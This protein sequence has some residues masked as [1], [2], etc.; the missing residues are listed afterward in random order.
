MSETTRSLASI[1]RQ[2]L[3]PRDLAAVFFRHKKLFA[4]SFVS[5]LLVGVAY[6]ALFPT[7]KSEATFQLGKARIDPAVTALPNVSPLLQSQEIGEEE[8]NSQVELLRDDEVLR[9]V[10]ERTGLAQPRSWLP[11]WTTRNSDQR[12]EKTV[13][14]L[15]KQIDIQPVRKSR[16]I[17]ISY[18]ATDPQLA[19]SVVK[20]LAEVYLARQA[21]LRRPAG[22]AAFFD[23]QVRESRQALHSAQTALVRFS[24]NG[25]VASASLERDLNVQKLVEAQASEMGLQAGIAETQERIRA[26]DRKMSDLPEHRVTQ[27]H[28]SDNPQLQEKL[29]SRLLELQLKRTE[30]LTKFQPSYR[31][32]QEADQEIAQA[33]AALKAEVA[34]PLRDEV[35]EINPDYTWASAERVKCLIDLQGLEKRLQIVGAQISKYQRASETL[36]AEVIEQ[37]DLEQA[38]KAAED[39]YLLYANKRE[40]ARIGD[41]LDS[42]GILNV[43]LAQPPRVPTV[44]VLPLLAG[45][46]LSFA[47]ALL[48]SIALVFVVDRLDPTVRTPADVIELLG[49]PVLAT[50]PIAPRGGTRMRSA[51]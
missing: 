25:K 40:E 6:T 14:R 27:V 45:I 26:L 38:V 33:E 11:E 22:Q 9:Q 5:T 35:T 23:E 10:S 24:R 28:N 36:A 50:F 39:K 42:K 15:K 49:A 46:W 30:L 13:A 44:P 12:L 29:K 17:A 41:A 7:Y 1:S 34:R 20:T 21:N 32:V 3:T 18:R 43:S 8:L 16:L 4:I 47:A 31:L 37:N 48:V 19:L 51:S 2:P